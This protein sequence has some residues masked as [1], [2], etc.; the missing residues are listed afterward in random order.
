MEAANTI[1][2]DD[3]PFISVELDEQNAI[4]DYSGLDEGVVR[5]TPYIN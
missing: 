2:N 5:V 4:I 3:Y 1:T